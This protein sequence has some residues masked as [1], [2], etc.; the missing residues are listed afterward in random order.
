MRSQQLAHTLILGVFFWYLFG[1]VAFVFFP[2]AMTAKQPE[3]CS[4]LA[5]CFVVALEWGLRTGD[6]GEAMVDVVQSDPRRYLQF[7][8]TV[9]YFLLISTILLNVIFGIIVDAFGEL[10]DSQ[11]ELKKKMLNECFICQVER[12]VFEDPKINTSFVHHV[13]KQHNI[14]HY[15]AFIIAIS[16]KPKTE[17]TGTEQYVVEELKNNRTDW[18]PAQRSL[19]LVSKSG[20]EE[21]AEKDRSGETDA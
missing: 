8:Y 16:L 21:E 13:K 18:F 15:I 7:G 4:S 19:E 10:R 14:W 2:L 20:E 11:D 17:L 12:Q 3:S 9:I 6:V 1:L 5:G